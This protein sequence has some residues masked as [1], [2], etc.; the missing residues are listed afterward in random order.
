MRFRPE[1]REQLELARRA[2][3][4]VLVASAVLVLGSS[5]S[6][7][8]ETP[9]PG[10][11]SLPA[12]DES[13]SYR[14]YV[15]VWGYHSAIFVEQPAQWRLGPEGNEA[16]PIVEYGWG[17]RRFYMESNYAPASLLSSALLPTQSVVYVRG[18]GR[19]PD[20]FVVGG[21]IYVRECAGPELRRLTTILEAQMV[22]TSGGGRPR[23]YPPTPEYV[24]RFYPG[25]EYYV[26]WTNCNEWTVRML[27]RAGLARASER[28]FFAQ[29]ASWHLTGFR[30]A[31]RP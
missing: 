19:P 17:D 28:V 24:G 7:G 5:V 26:I 1:T 14:V 16:A 30:V 18:H 6:I 10:P 29:Q 12:F 8:L 3:A 23:A 4:I 22:R 2:A 31:P 21:Q 25:R 9:P 27:E 11:V 20:E 13:A 15:L